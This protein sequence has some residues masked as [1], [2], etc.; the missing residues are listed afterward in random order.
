MEEDADDELSRAVVEEKKEF[1]E[2]CKESRNPIVWFVP[3]KLNSR[4]SFTLGK[5]NKR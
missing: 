5:S 1:H 3:T 2:D 4:N